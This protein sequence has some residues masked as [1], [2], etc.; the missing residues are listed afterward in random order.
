MRLFCDVEEGEKKNPDKINKVPVDTDIFYPVEV[1]PFASFEGDYS[2]DDH[3]GNDVKPMEACCDVIEGPEIIRKK[4]ITMCNLSGIFVG[5]NA[6]KNKTSPNGEPNIF[7][8]VFGVFP[9]GGLMSQND[10]ETGG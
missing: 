2:H 7:E 3:S 10:K 1:L 8:G 5:F 4:G 9:F 6:E